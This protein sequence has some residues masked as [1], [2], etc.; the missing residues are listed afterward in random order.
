MEKHGWSPALLG[1]QPGLIHSPPC[2]PANLHSAPK[3]QGRSGIASIS[4]W[5]PVPGVRGEAP[6]LGGRGQMSSE[7]QIKKDGGKDAF[8][9]KTAKKKQ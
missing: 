3:A 7:H 4:Y 8:F 1:P 6:C 5:H 2:R 9:K